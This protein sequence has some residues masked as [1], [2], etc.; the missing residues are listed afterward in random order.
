MVGAVGTILGNSGQNIAN[1]S[2]ARNKS[3]R[4]AL[5]IIELDET[6]PANV[7]EAIRAIPG[8]TSATGISL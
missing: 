8:V 4:N 5:S 3:E 6:L 2:L 1:L 7:M